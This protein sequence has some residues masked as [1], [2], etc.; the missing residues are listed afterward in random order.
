MNNNNQEIKATL[1]LTTQALSTLGNVNPVFVGIS[2]ITGIINE[3]IGCYES[4]QLE[5]RLNMLE[6]EI[7]HTLAPDPITCLII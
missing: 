4:T 6:K 3:L 2:L 7:E 5:K 1:S